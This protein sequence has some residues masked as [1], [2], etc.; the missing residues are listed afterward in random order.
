MQKANV[1]I[2]LCLVLVISGVI[3]YLYIGPKGSEGSSD[4]EERV[5]NIESRLSEQLV[6]SYGELN[7]TAQTITLVIMHIGTANVT[8]SEIR[9]NNVLNSSGPGWEG[10]KTLAPGQV[11]EITLYGLKYF[12]DG[13]TSDNCHP[14]MV[15]TTNGN[16]FYLDA[17][18]T[19]TFMFTEQMTFTGI[20]W[21]SNKI[22]VSIKNTG[23]GASSIDSIYVGT[24]STNLELQTDISPSLPKTISAGD[25]ATF[26]ITY[27]WTSGTGYYFKVVTTQGMLLNFNAVAP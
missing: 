14:I 19:L 5:N 7:R 22:D 23:S 17:I 25:S 15:I 8:I 4:L 16:T 9:V 12:A 21:G 26:S 10:S 1:I 11:G 3:A 2:S 6:L 13:F 24:S 18:A 20:T 27:S